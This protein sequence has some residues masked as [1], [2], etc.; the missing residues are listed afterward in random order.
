MTDQWDLCPLIHFI[1]K[2]LAP[3][4]TLKGRIAYLLINNIYFKK[5]S[6]GTRKMG[7]QLRFLLTQRPWSRVLALT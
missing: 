6:S 3:M 1:F 7:Q 2:S 5:L 4:T